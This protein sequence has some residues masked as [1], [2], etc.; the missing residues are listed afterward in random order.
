M[1]TRVNKDKQP[2]KSIPKIPLSSNIHEG[3]VHFIIIV[4]S[5]G[6]IGTIIKTKNK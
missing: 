4:M 1:T 2:I 5:T 3:G 6:N